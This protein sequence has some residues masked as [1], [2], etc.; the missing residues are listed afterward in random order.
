MTAVSRGLGA[1]LGSFFG[2]VFVWA[3]I[4][5]A[6][7]HHLQA[8]ARSAVSYGIAA[9]SLGM[10]IAVVRRTR[11]A[12]IRRD[13]TNG[14]RIGEALLA[15]L[16]AAEKAHQPVTG[17]ADSGDPASAVMETVTVVLRRQI[18]PRLDEPPRCWLG[19]L[20]ML[21]D[22][23]PW[24][25]SV[26]RE[27]PERGERPLHFV[28]QICCADLPPDL[29]AGLG[30]RHGWLR[31]FIDPN[32]GD[33]Q[34]SDAFAIVHTGTLG[35]ERASPADLGP[36]H[37]GVYTGWDYQYCGGGENVP[38]L[39]PRWPVDLVATPNEARVEGRTVRV[40]PSHSRRLSE[41]RPHRM[42][43][44]HDGVQSDATI[45]PTEH[46]LLFQLASDEA[47]HWCWGDVGAYYFYISPA[48][49]RRGDFDRASIV[50]ECH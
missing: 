40:A 16:A 4:E 41:T 48:D 5:T 10:G 44:Y 13:R 33:P 49:L 19:G 47:M 36:V 39:W 12:M 26:S 3:V 8:P 38:R 43:G 30:P 28:A 25:Y 9:V 6:T 17:I 50:L 37:D 11:N 34:G 7:R 42:G 15:V 35:S 45:G 20:P 18:P 1:A 46:V 22:A 23:V 2:L 31:L 29:W 32:Q 24:P 21:P 14:R 27:Y